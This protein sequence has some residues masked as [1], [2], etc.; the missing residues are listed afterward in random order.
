MR[1]VSV[2]SLHKF[3][4]NYPIFVNDPQRGSVPAFPQLPVLGIEGI[5]PKLYR[6]LGSKAV[7]Y[8]TKE[9]LRD[10]ILREGS[11]PYLPPPK[12]LVLRQKPL[13]HWC[14]YESYESPLATRAAL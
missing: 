8:D 4:R 13:I 3:E 5:T 1:L 14:S 12:G 11:L 7:V 9:R 6:A 10:F 2:G